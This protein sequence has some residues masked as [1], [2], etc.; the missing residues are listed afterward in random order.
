MANRPIEIR[1]HDHLREADRKN[2]RNQ[3]FFDVGMD[4][5]LAATIANWGEDDYCPYLKV[6]NEDGVWRARMDK[7]APRLFSRPWYEGITALEAVQAVKDAFPKAALQGLATRR[8][9][10]GPLIARIDQAVRL[11]ERVPGEVRWDQTFDRVQQ[12][13][14][15]YPQGW[16][17][18]PSWG[19]F[20]PDS[21]KSRLLASFSLSLGVRGL[22]YLHIDSHGGR[23]PEEFKIMELQ[24]ATLR[25]LAAKIEKIFPKTA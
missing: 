8:R 2:S 14:T 10:V 6:W 9:E 22:D 17:L 1:T 11:I 16:T 13:A 23:T 20:A 15:A 4:L 5:V 19:L 3:E 18:N 21:G 12:Y 24:M 25:R 7:V